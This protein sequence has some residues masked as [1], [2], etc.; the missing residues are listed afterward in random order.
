[1]VPSSPYDWLTIP[2]SW[3]LRY[4]EVSS[5]EEPELFFKAHLLGTDLYVGTPFDRAQADSWTDR[6]RS[7]NSWWIPSQTLKSWTSF[8]SKA[9]RPHLTCLSLPEIGLHFSTCRPPNRRKM[10]CGTI[11]KPWRWIWAKRP[12]GGDLWKV[13]HPVPWLFFGCQVQQLKD[14]IKQLQQSIKQEP[15]LKKHFASWCFH[16]I[17]ETPGTRAP[18]KPCRKGK[19]CGTGAQHFFGCSVDSL[20]LG[21]LFHSNSSEVA[22]RCRHNTPPPNFDLLD[23]IRIHSV[24]M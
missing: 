21:Y 3:S 2:F 7:L 24:I 20:A 1:M 13:Y 15:P 12:P 5:E 8:W 16:L 9:P 23:V 19:H 10:R 11:F 4:V 14:Q 18:A 17:G 6:S 22:S